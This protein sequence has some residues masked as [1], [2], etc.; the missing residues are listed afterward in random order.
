MNKSG[1]FVFLLCGALLL[2]AN[3]LWHK[4]Q[5]EQS[6]LNVYQKIDL[7]EQQVQKIELENLE[8][9]HENQQIELENQQIEREN[10]QIDRHRQEL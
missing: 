2:V 5:M 1:W 10:R 3:H 9:E 8:I 4:Q 6:L 7:L